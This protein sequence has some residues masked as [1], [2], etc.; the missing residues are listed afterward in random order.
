MP[1][2]PISFSIPSCKIV[3][4]VP[5]KKNR[6]L[7]PLI[8]GNMST[9]I[10]NTEDEYYKHYQDCLFGLTMKKGG[11]DC[12][13]HYEILANGC[14]PWFENIESIPETIM[15]RFPKKTVQ[16]I[17]KQYNHVFEMANKSS[18]EERLLQSENFQE[19]YKK[20]I[21]DLLEYTRKFLTTKATAQYILH[22]IKCD[23]TNPSVLYLGDSLY[24]DYL[25]CLTLHGFKD[26]LGKNCHDFPKIPHLYKSYPAE[27][28]SNSYGHGI[29]YSRLLQDEDYRDDALDITIGRDIRDHK[30]DIIVYGSIHRSDILWDY[31]RKFYTPNEIV[32]LCGEDLHGVCDKRQ[33]GRLGYH[34]FVR[35][36]L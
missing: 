13:R 9:Y 19:Q 12:N 2:Y 6:I 8:P 3:D 22:T 4:H 35:E 16:E 29:T 27:H 25:R 34:V 10:Y 15:T 24:P 18:E 33:L 14:I 30:Y 21:H 7:S 28:A 23:K 20:V 1:V 5:D 32:V 17:M 31:V 36:L 26:L 11:W